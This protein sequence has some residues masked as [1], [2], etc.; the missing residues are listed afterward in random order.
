MHGYKWFANEQ[1]SPEELQIILEKVKGKSY[2][3]VLTHTCPFEWQPTELFLPSVDQSAVDRSM[4][5]FLGEVERSIT[6]NKFY[7]GHFHGNKNC[8]KFEMLFD[9]IKV[10]E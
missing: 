4:E 7:C 3:I 8:G 9:K 10:I 6:Y 5:I 1:L 2:D